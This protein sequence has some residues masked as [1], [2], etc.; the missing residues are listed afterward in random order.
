MTDRRGEFMWSEAPGMAK[1]HELLLLAGPPGEQ[2]GVFETFQ[3]K[4][5]LVCE[6]AYYCSTGVFPHIAEPGP[7]SQDFE[8]LWELRLPSI[9]AS[10]DGIK[11]FGDRWGA[12]ASGPVNPMPWSN[13]HYE[14]PRSFL[15][16]FLRTGDRRFFD[17]GEISVRHHADIDVQ[18]SPGPNRYAEGGGMRPNPGPGFVWM[19]YSH[20]HQGLGHVSHFHLGGMPHYYLLQGDPRIREVMVETADH[21]ANLIEDPPTTFAVE[22]QRS[23]KD[24]AAQE[25][26]EAAIGGDWAMARDRGW[27]LHLL[28][29]AYEATGEVRY[30]KCARR[31]IRDLEAMWK[32]PQPHIIDGKRV[33]EF[34]PPHGAWATV[35]RAANG[36]TSGLDGWGSAILLYGVCQFHHVNKRLGLVKRARIE[37]MMHQHAQAIADFLWLDGDEGFRYGEGNPPRPN[38]FWPNSIF[39]FPLSYVARECTDP[40]LAEI[41]DKAYRGKMGIRLQFPSEEGRPYDE[42]N[43]PFWLTPHYLAM[44]RERDC[45]I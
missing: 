7:E 4:P 3:S 40:R 21:V 10:R 22:Y 18:H 13:H 14:E 37:P 42:T 12:G 23:P 28:V 5:L 43:I 11:H 25:D 41:A 2:P 20:D 29:E 1:T 39:L 36:I 17:E 24:K 35:H 45:D 8:K 33:G 30:I 38:R 26:P 34:K 19:H 31:L 32:T 6:P 44:C 9:S 27:M 15:I 16:Q